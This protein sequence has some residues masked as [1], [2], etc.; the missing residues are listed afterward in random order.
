VDARFK[1]SGDPLPGGAEWLANLGL[2]WKPIED[3]STALQISYVGERSRANLDNR[4]SL[5]A[6]TLYDLTISHQGLIPGL[7]FFMGVKNI[8]D[9]NVKYPQQLTT[10]FEGDAFLPY[11]NDYPRPGRRWWLSLNYDIH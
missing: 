10:N 9:E 5:P 4:S 3:W 2:I 7:K 1:E 11:P 6:T 8:T